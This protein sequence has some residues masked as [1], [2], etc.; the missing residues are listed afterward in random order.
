MASKIVW[1]EPKARQQYGKATRAGRGFWHCCCG[2]CWKQQ[3]DP[4]IRP[5]CPQCGEDTT[6]PKYPAY[7]VRGAQYTPYND[8]SNWADFANK[9]MSAQAQKNFQYG[10]RG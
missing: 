6:G 1:T 10:R 7:R 5:D 2:H 8:G 4:K 9:D 3:D